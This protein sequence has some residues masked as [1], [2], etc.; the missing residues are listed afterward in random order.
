MRSSVKE[1]RFILL[2]NLGGTTCGGRIAE[3]QTL[4][5]KREPDFRD[6]EI[7][8]LGEGYKGVGI[9]ATKAGLDVAEGARHVDGAERGDRAVFDP[10][11]DCSRAV[12]VGVGERRRAE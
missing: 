2:V 5:R 11:R 10:D 8:V 3:G 4:S 7:A 9:M 6:D 12:R 1:L